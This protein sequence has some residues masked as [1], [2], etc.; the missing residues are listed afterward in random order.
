[1]GAPPLQKRAVPVAQVP[2][3]RS[4]NSVYVRQYFYKTALLVQKMYY[5]HHTNVHLLVVH[6]RQRIDGQPELQGRGRA[7]GERYRVPHVEEVGHRQ[8]VVL[9]PEPN[10]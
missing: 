7:L 4:S 1:M 9:L 5:G 2:R 8:R 3:T 6:Q 10:F